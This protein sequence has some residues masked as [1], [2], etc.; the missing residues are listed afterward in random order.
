[1]ALKNA[2]DTCWKKSTVTEAGFIYEVKIDFNTKSSIATINFVL[3]RFPMIQDEEIGSWYQLKGNI[4]SD[5]QY[6]T[7]IKDLD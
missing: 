4:S 1:M 7:T 5:G 3:R 2:V 6:L